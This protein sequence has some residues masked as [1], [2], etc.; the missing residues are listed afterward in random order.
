MSRSIWSRYEPL[1]DEA[2]NDATIALSVCVGGSPPA[3]VEGP[4]DSL[5]RRH[6]P[7]LRRLLSAHAGPGLA[8]LVCSAERLEASAWYAAR[9]DAIH[10]LIVGRHNQADVFLPSDPRLSLRHLALLLH[11][12]EGK[13]AP[14]FRVCDL[15]TPLAFRDEDGRPLQ[16]VEAAG[17]LLLRCASYAILLFPTGVPDDSWPEDPDEAWARVPPRVYAEASPAEPGG[18]QERRLQVV[19]PAPPPP[20]STLALALPG[21]IL[22]SA[23]ADDSAPARGEI[24]LSS[25]RG[26]VR[27]RLGVRDARQGV[28]LG[29]YE[30]C[31]G[32]GLPLLDDNSLSRVHLLLIELD[33][34]LYAIDTSSKNGSWCG[35][36]RIEATALH[37]GMALRLARDVQVE[38]HPYH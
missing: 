22:P 34:G 29:R 27:L 26:R 38:W 32:G 25:P 16:S 11:P 1:R 5:F 2:S 37:P 10:A 7:T 28:L 13:A 8:F 14:R 15:R 35:P 23:T 24:L 21:P 33:G 18:W 6:Y 36:Q 19:P 3:L 30:R 20:G 31:D 12:A 17:P 9:P 4:F